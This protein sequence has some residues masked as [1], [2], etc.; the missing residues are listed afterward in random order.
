MQRGSRGEIEIS[1]GFGG[2]GSGNK[3]TVEAPSGHVDALRGGRWGAIGAKLMRTDSGVYRS[4]NLN[5]KLWETNSPCVLQLIRLILNRTLS[6]YFNPRRSIPPIVFLC[7]SL[8]MPNIYRVDS[9]QYT[10]STHAFGKKLIQRFSG[11]AIC[12][13]LESIVDKQFHRMV[14]VAGINAKTLLLPAG[15]CLGFRTMY[16]E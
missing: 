1:A 6:D 15:P 11:L 9:H 5:F 13:S 16:G 2:S 3:R 10:P 12:T 4:Q 14:T 8:R 7:P